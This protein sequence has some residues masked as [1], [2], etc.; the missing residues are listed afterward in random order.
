MT[1]RPAVLVALSS[2]LLVACMQSQDFEGGPSAAPDGQGREASVPLSCDTARDPE[3]CGACGHACLGGACADGVCQPV[4]LATAARPSFAAPIAIEEKGVV[5][6]D[7]SGVRR[8]SRHGG[9]ATMLARPVLDMPGP[10]RG[11]W[12]EQLVLEG[13]DLFVRSYGA[14][15]V[16]RVTGPFA[17][18]PG[19]L[20]VVVDGGAIDSVTAF[21]V[22][23]T[24]IVYAKWGGGF[25]V[26]PRSGC[27]GGAQRPLGERKDV[28][29]AKLVRDQ[30]LYTS[31]YG[32]DTTIRSIARSPT[33]PSSV[34]TGESRSVA[35]DIGYADGVAADDA[36]AFVLGSRSVIVRVPLRGGQPERTIATGQRLHV[37]SG[38]AVDER[39]VYWADQGRGSI[40]RAQ[41]TGGGPEP[42]ATDLER[43][44]GVAVDGEAVYFTTQGPSDDADGAVMKV[45]KPR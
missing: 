36:S 1:R 37:P 12:V 34:L 45:A 8:V 19:K 23:A 39:F 11:A 29:F 17:S 42:V 16:W 4:V 21:D 24:T 2:A 33:D 15:R 9:E 26:C 27:V 38:I 41:K 31:G 28:A 5:W 40:F 6:A 25:F 7:A 18:T 20:E 14:G 22:D 35:S 10:A 32:I 3:N 13:G 43:P 44:Y 30:I